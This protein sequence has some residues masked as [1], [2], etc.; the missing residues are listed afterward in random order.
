MWLE[1]LRDWIEDLKSYRTRTALTLLAVSWGTIAVVLLLAFGE[2]LGDQF[3]NGLRNEGD[4]II[5]VSGGVTGMRYKGLPGG[6][7]IRL[8]EE[9]LV[10]IKRGIPEVELASP[11]YRRKVVLGNGRIQIATEC[12]GVNPGVEDMK[13]MYP[14]S[15]G[16]FINEVDVVER[17]HVMFLG[18]GIA[19]DI[20]G[21]EDP[22]GK[23][24]A[25]DGTPFTVVGLMQKKI[26]T[27]IEYGLQSRRAVIPHSTFRVIYGSRYPES[28]VIR[29]RDASDQQLIKEQ[30]YRILGNEHHFDSRDLRALGVSDFIE[31]E[32]NAKTV[33]L[34]LSIFLGTLGALTLVVAGVGVAN[35]MF[36]IVKERTREIGIRIAVGAKRG[37]I[38]AQFTFEAFLLAIVGGGIGFLISWIIVAVVRFLPMEGGIMQFLGRPRLSLEVIVTSISILASIVLA[39]GFF[40]A[41]RA[42]AVDPVESLRY[43]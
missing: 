31:A 5:V 27:S 42:A 16:R 29:P 6:R 12:E 22:L 28:L 14:M 32:K 43:E 2:G 10:L 25:L 26:E 15:G 34:G 11:Q 35:I 17:R 7:R 23:T 13:R 9:D 18:S 38:L 3:V 36:I 33:A 41:W 1:F 24:I 39:A 8:T 19:K 21:G 37:H 40:P 20:F 4:R 30:I